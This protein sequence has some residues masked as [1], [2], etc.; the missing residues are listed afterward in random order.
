MILQVTRRHFFIFSILFSF[1][2]FSA[3]YIYAQNEN[4]LFR[5]SFIDADKTFS[6]SVPKN[7]LT[8][9]DGYIKSSFAFV[10]INGAS[11][12]FVSLFPESERE[13]RTTRQVDVE[14]APVTEWFGLPSS[15]KGTLSKD[16][17]VNNYI[18]QN[19]RFRLKYKVISATM[20]RVY[21][22]DVC[23][24]YCTAK[25]KIKRR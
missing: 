12:N 22:E 23:G 11:I 4:S 7:W 17:Y 1:F 24:N 6:I 18:D 3:D 16:D 14:Y 8:N 21:G 2:L 9:Q 5:K 15:L 19:F 20:K 25:N 10:N 13:S